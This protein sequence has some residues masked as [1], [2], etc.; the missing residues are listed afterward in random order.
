MKK[1]VSIVLLASACAATP[2]L[3]QAAPDAWWAPGDHR[4]FP[5]YVE[6]PNSWGRLGLVNVSGTIDTTDHPFFEALGTN[7]RACVSCHQ[8]ADGMSLALTSIRRRWAATKGADPIFAAIDGM[9]CPDLPAADPASHSLLLER[10]LFRI[11]LPW[12]PR[13]RRKAVRSRPNSRSRSSAI[14]PA[15]TP[16]RCTASTA[17][18]TKSRSTA[19][20]A[21]PRTCAT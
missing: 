14:R 8:P 10:G 17:K 15:A 7:G 9:N 21:P 1:Y 11:P 3:A 18:D 12:P 19:A 6:Y 5:A 20:R 13:R 2:A 4:P 16:I